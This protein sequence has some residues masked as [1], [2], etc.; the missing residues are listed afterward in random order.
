MDKAEETLRAFIADYYYGDAPTEII[1]N[2]AYECIK[3]LKEH[4][5]EIVRVIND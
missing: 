1:E 3:F 2:D 4:G 5:F